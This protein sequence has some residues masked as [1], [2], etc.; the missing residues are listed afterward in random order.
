MDDI[1]IRIIDLPLCTKGVTVPSDDGFYNI[2]INAKYSKA[3]QGK[4]L[5]HEL[6]HI[7]HFDFDNFDPIRFIEE[8]A[9][10]I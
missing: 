9:R 1:L 4:I 7:E 3:Q 5:E 10:Q 6:K 8:R 2:Y